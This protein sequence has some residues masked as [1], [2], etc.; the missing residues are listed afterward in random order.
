MEVIM[1]YYFKHNQLSFRQKGG[2]APQKIIFIPT[3]LY[4]ISDNIT[5]FPQLKQNKNT[6]CIYIFILY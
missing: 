5:F 1:K 2:K 3:A 4:F 6:T